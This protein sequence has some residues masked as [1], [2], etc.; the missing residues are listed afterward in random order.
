MA[1]I[2]IVR[3]EYST[4][5]ELVENDEVKSRLTIH[6]LKVNVWGK[7]LTA[8]GIGGVNTKEE[9]RHQGY[10]RAVLDEALKVMLNDKQ[11]L[12]LL[13]GIPDYYY[14]WGFGSCL[15]QNYISIPTYQAE[16]AV[17][18]HLVR[19]LTEYDY[20]QIL[21]I[22]HQNN[23]YRTGAIVRD[24]ERFRFRLSSNFGEKAEVYVLTKDETIEGYLVLD[25]NKRCVNIAEIEAKKPAAYYSGLAFLAKQAIDKR[26]SAITG[27]ILWDHPFALI[28]RDYGLKATTNYV[29]NA[30]GMGRII[31]QGSVLQKL[32][33]EIFSHAGLSSEK[34]T[35]LFSTELGQTKIGKGPNSHLIE[36]DQ[37]TLLQLLF[38]YRSAAECS[39]EK[40]LDSKT[41]NT[42]VLEKMFPLRTAHL[43]G[44]DKF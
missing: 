37:K 1:V 17:L 19:P 33:P 44:P 11:D 39:C 36:T 8:G 21:S 27:N 22:Y 41:L 2:N 42:A 10:S 15:P 24:L 3:K 14:R 9:Y 30:D 6:N 26:V 13:F 43:Y 34:I 20:T 40:K 18:T 25:Q 31:T 35:L 12:S 16:R 4:R 23:N 28:A 38:G 32:A 7:I 5:I 29:Y